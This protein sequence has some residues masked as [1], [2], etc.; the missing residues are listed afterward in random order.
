MD[1]TVANTMD[2]TIFMAGSNTDFINYPY[3]SLI[4]DSNG[5][6]IATGTINFF[7]QI[8]N[9]SQTYAVS[10]NLDSIPVNFSCTVYYNYDT[11]VCAL[12]YPC[13]TAGIRNDYLFNA[14]KIYPNPSNGKFQFTIDGSQFDENCK[15]EIYNVQGER[16]YQSAITN[17][18]FDID[19]SNQPNGI[20]IVKIY[21]GQTVLTKKIV[22]R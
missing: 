19:L 20:Y 5:D 8:G 14:P 1:S 13:T 6:T 7:G 10:T 17:T 11:L 18:K 3:I 12:S 16:I 21:D 4:T 2:V 15:V 22:I 9:T